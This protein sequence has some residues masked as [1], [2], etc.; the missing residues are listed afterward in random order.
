MV[1]Q[2]CR[3]YG[4]HFVL[5][6]MV[7]AGQSGPVHQPQLGEPSRSVGSC[8]GEDSGRA[9]RPYLRNSGTDS[10]PAVAQAQLCLTFAG[11]ER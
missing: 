6:R 11:V 7:S 9:V 2:C 1:G 10:V 5:A 3:G 4:E 8:S